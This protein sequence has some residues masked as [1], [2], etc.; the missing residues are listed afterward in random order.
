M[1]PGSAAR[2]LTVLP[3][4]SIILWPARELARKGPTVSVEIETKLI[5]GRT[6]ADAQLRCDFCGARSSTEGACGVGAKEAASSYAR[7]SAT[8]S[9]G[10][11]SVTVPLIERKKRYALLRD[12]CAACSVRRSAVH[13][14]NAWSH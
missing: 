5:D 11:T 6:Y 13:S 9:Q 1:A 8:V 4:G 10:W 2:R 3:R 7:A 12:K 14:E